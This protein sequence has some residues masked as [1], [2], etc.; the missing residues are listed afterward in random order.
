MSLAAAEQAAWVRGVSCLRYHRAPHVAGSVHWRWRRPCFVIASR[1]R[2]SGKVGR[3]S[4]GLPMLK[5]HSVVGKAPNSAIPS[6]SHCGRPVSGPFKSCQGLTEP[7][8]RVAFITAILQ[9]L[10]RTQC[11]QKSMLLSNGYLRMHQFRSANAQRTGLDSPL[12]SL[13]SFHENVESRG[14]STLFDAFP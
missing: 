2:Y 14:S 4:H 8:A 3:A 7:G 10:V 9:G 12:H 13:S 1:V 11:S 6:D 5:H